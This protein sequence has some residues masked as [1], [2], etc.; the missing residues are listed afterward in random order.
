MD[1]DLSLGEVREFSCG[2]L[3]WAGEAEHRGLLN[4]AGL[5]RTGGDKEGPGACFGA[6]NKQEMKKK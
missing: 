2:G 5:R 1:G 3:Y 6:V 4:V